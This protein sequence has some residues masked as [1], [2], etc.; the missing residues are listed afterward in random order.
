MEIPTA[1]QKWKSDN[2]YVSW[3]NFSSDVSGKIDPRVTVTDCTL[4]D[5]EQQAGIVFSKE[6]KVTI[7]KK[8]DEV[9]I[10][11]IEAGMPMVS[12]EDLEAVKAIAKEGLHAQLYVLSR[13][14]KSD[15]DMVL[16]CDVPGVQISMPSGELQIK[17]KLKWSEDK[18]ISTAVDIVD[19]A[20]AHGLWVNLSPYDTTRADPTFLKRYIETIS[21]DTK[22]DRIR[23]VDTVGSARP[24]AI[25]YLTKM[26]KGW[27]GAIPLEIHAHNDF[28]LAVANSLAALEAGA[29][30]V[31]T[32][33]NGIGERVGNAS[34]EEVVLALRVLY[35][36]DTGMRY[37][38]LYE[39]SQLVQKLSGVRLQPHKSVVGEGA[40][41]HESGIS[42]DGILEL[43]WTGEAFAPQFVGQTR[44]IILGKKSGKNS[45][46]YELKNL[47]MSATP[48]QVNDI[49]TAV[50]DE[51]IKTK[52]PI[53]QPRFVEIAR[54]ILQSQ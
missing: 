51:S 34:T 27:A 1:T 6:D 41:R 5:G 53:G 26:I 42:V 46:E 11:Q 21:R 43:P 31:S 9:G 32:T 18:V 10:H 2:W 24:A 49:L 33:V 8:L 19:Y 20:K 15:V 47:G 37:E 40:F 13:A 29:S 25:A 54:R 4:R 39:L 36:I 22:V 35:G 28:G 16:S 38:R 30:A 23:I 44:K 7:A 48:E 3:L 52:G 17:Y 12:H 45:I 50:K 14:I